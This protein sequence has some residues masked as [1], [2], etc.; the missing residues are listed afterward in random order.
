[1]VYVSLWS[2]RQHTH[3]HT[4]TQVRFFVKTNLCADVQ[5]WEIEWER[6]S[7]AVVPQDSEHFVVV[8]ARVC[9]CVRVC[10][11]AQNMQQ[12]V[13]AYEW[14]K[15]V[16][17]VVSN[18]AF[19]HNFMQ[20]WHNQSGWCPTRSFMKS[21]PLPSPSTPRTWMQIVRIHY[22][23]AN[24]VASAQCLFAYAPYLCMNAATQFMLYYGVYYLS[25]SQRLCGCT[26]IYSRPGFPPAPARAA[27]F[28]TLSANS[29]VHARREARCQ[30]PGR[31]RSHASGAACTHHRQNDMRLLIRVAAPPSLRRAPAHISNLPKSWR[32]LAACSPLA[33]F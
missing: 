7:P 21:C 9:V 30:I 26:C 10:L 31:I 27:A 14:R 24:H 2:T 20:I 25:F 17:C 16:A 18:C 1:M 28:P 11:R 12:F 6:F 8:P 19:A 29:C 3:I 15:L 22:T 23:G 5:D 33:V 13:H 32:A 4:R